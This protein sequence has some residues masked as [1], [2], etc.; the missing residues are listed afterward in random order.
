[1][2]VYADNAATTQINEEALQAMLPYYQTHYGNPSSVH[3]PGRA[4]KKA[5]V[6]A[7]EVVAKALGASA[8]E[9]YF[10]SGGTEANNWVLKSVAK[11]QGKKG[12]RHLI[13]TTIEHPS[14]LEV[15]KELEKD[16]FTVTLIDV[17]EDGVVQLNALADA[18]TDDTALVSVMYA[19]NEIGTVQPIAEIGEICH[20]NGVLLH[21][22]AVQAV[23][24]LAIDVEEENIDFLSLSAHKFHGPKGVGALYA[25][26]GTRLAGYLNGGA[27]E[28]KKR[29]GTEN[30]PGIVGMQVA[31]ENALATR[32]EAARR[33]TALRDELANAL[34]AMPRTR[35]NGHK[36]K[37]LPNIVNVSFEGI[38]GEGL[39][40]LLDMAGISASSGSACSSDSLEPSHVLLA[41]GLPHEIAHGSLRLSLGSDTTQQ[42]I[43]Y[44]IETIPPMVERL[45]DMSPLWESINKGA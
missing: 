36:E 23:G 29:A 19:N 37:R 9:I 41:I 45:R 16:G 21:T 15:L 13:S 14:V 26:K 39:L 34:T 27:Q 18:I 40:L 25:R 7:R 33:I 1:M 31:L 3:A 44:L 28:S 30:V 38:E 11:T 8:E 2:K 5:V 17:D 20:R 10:T 12:K 42:D 32:E 35:L 43:D 4:A 22:D 6:E 24:A